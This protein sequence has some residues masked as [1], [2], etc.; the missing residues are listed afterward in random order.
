MRFPS[1]IVHLGAGLFSSLSRIGLF[2]DPVSRW[3]FDRLYEQYKLRIEA[4]DVVR[5]FQLISDGS[6][7]FD[8]G[9]NVGI[10]TI[11]MAR[12][13]GRSGKVVAVEPAAENLR[14][15]RRR[16]DIAQMSSW[17]Q[18][19]DGVASNRVGI[20][21]LVLTPLQPWDHHIGRNGEDVASITVDALVAGL[22]PGPVSYI[23]IDVQ[24][25]E[26]LVLEGMQETLRTHK[27]AICIEI[28]PPSLQRFNTT[29]EKLV[30]FIG[31]SQY[32][33][34]EITPSGFPVLT[35]DRASIALHDREYIDVLFLHQR[36]A[37]RY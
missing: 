29:F 32:R 19:F 8:I 28:H 21:K 18:I 23:K 34:H 17:V 31:Q 10:L 16:L 2:R 37:H 26:Q 30:E 6:I 1:Q 4:R 3:T 20:E 7:A 36:S 13:V 35:K 33:V 9:A 5:T 22:P 24:G 14:S 11:P 15:L 12:R 27:P 25:A